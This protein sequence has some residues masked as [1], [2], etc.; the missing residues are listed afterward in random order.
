MFEY[1]IL[2]EGSVNQGNGFELIYFQNQRRI[3]RN[4]S[5]FCTHLVEYLKSE[6]SREI[7]SDF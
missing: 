7:K 2:L 1:T 4:M 5:T 3:V 6:N